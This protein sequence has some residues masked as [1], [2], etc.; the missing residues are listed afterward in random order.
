MNLAFNGDFSIKIAYEM[1][2]TRNN[3]RT[4]WIPS[5]TTFGNGRDRLELES[6]CRKSFMKDFSQMKE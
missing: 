5:L 1:L 3:K 4:I 6:L 2:S